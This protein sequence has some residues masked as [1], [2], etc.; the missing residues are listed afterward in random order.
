MNRILTGIVFVVAVGASLAA[1]F[2]VTGA[3]FPRRVKKTRRMIDELPTRSFWIGMVNLVFALIL[4]FVIIRLGNAFG[5]V[6]ERLM[7]LIALVILIPLAI[8][9]MV[10]LTGVAQSMGARLLPE[11]GELV[12]TIWATVALTAACA[13][14]LVGW[15]ILLPYS[16]FLGL[17]GFVLGVFSKQPAETVAVD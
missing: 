6:G 7:L 4:S 12:R 8:G 3:F 11:K 1:F 10:G 16:C 15:F 9:L 13:L 17:G 2:P 14:P 5:G